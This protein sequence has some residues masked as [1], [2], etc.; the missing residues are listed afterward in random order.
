MQTMQTME[1]PGDL[2]DQWYITRKSSVFFVTQSDT[3]ETQSV[4]FVSP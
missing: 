4:N 2:E 1:V 3:E